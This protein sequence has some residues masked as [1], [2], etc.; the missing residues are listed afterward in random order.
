V[1]VRSTRATF[2]SAF[3]V[4][5]RPTIRNT[6]WDAAKFEVAG[7]RFADLSEP[8]YGVAL[9]NDGKYGYDVLGNEMSLS[10]LRSPIYPDPLADEGRQTFTYALY[11]HT[12]SWLEGGVLMEA[13]DLN[14]PLLARRCSSSEDTTWQG[15]GFSGLPLGLGTLKVLEDGG[16]LVLRTYEPQGA[17]GQVQVHLPPG[18]RAD[19]E[20]DLLENILGDADFTV[21]PFQVHSWRLARDG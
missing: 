20:L 9:L 5:E 13:E 12:G 16:G 10:L 7:H 15:I 8:G 1:A 11:P 3:G 2:E 6:S 19:V 21:T 4:V 18:W 14:Q 17:R